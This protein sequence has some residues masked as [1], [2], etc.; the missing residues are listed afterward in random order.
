MMTTADLKRIYDE[1]EKEVIRRHDPDFDSEQQLMGPWAHH[2]YY[3]PLCPPKP[4]AKPERAA[5]RD[6]TV[7]VCLACFCGT[8]VLIV[9]AW[10]WD[11]SR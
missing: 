11:L 9:A 8:L 1:K 7:P 4:T 6:W 5:A 2:Y 10:L 3:R